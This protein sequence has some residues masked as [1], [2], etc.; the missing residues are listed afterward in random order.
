M[1]LRRLVVLLMA[2]ALVASACG[3]DDDDSASGGGGGGAKNTGKVN[4][5]S[6][7]EPEETQAYQKIF[8]DLINSKTDYKAEVESAGNFEEQ[9][10]IRA[11]GGTLDLAAV[12]QPGAIAALADKGSIVSLEDLGFDIGDLNKTLGESFVALGEH[13]GK[14]YGI[15]TNINLKSMV[16]YP[17]AAFDKAGY[18]VPKTWD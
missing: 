1:R 5:L 7:G 15:P 14:H 11:E 12:P 6:A 10:Q 8:D 18:E 13:K 2:L 17:K 4:L 3:G 16:W 9:F